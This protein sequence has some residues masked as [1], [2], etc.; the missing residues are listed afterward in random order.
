VCKN[1]C[2][3]VAF[4]GTKTA[5]VSAVSYELHSSFQGVFLGERLSTGTASVFWLPLSVLSKQNGH[6]YETKLEESFDL[7]CCFLPL[8]LKKFFCNKK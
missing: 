1:K 2:N 4:T 6:R 8:A 3:T 7:F 5:V